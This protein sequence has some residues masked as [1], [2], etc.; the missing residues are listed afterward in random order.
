VL[1]AAAGAGF[2]K[3]EIVAMQS[4]T[5][6]RLYGLSEAAREADRAF[7]QRALAALGREPDQAKRLAQLNALAE[8]ALMKVP[9][10]ERAAL[11]PGLRTRAEI[12]SS[13][14]FYQDAITP[15]R[16]YLREVRCPV[17]AL[18][19][20]K[21]VLIRADKHAPQIETSLRKGGNKDFTVKIMPDLNHM[22]QTARTGLMEEA[23]DIEETVAPEVL[24]LI[25]DWLTARVPKQ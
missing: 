4:E 7:M 21:D 9:E 1:L 11:G 15:R 13:E 6:A 8:E 24:Q 2:T 23:K 25:G 22:F 12:L 17:L 18:N 5:M 16:D 14:N 19:G 3:G 10:K 20:G